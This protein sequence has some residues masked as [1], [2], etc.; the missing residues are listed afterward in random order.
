MS[1]VRVKPEPHEKRPG[2]DRVAVTLAAAGLASR[3]QA[4]VD[5]AAKRGVEVVVDAESMAVRFI[6]A[7]VA[8]AATDLRNLDAGESVRVHNACGGGSGK[9]GGDSSKYGVT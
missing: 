2:D 8:R 9:V 5:E 3:F 1:R 7:A 4:I 6:P